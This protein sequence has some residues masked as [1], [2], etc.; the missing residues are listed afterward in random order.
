MRRLHPAARLLT[1]LALLC[2]PAAGAAQ[3]RYG[4]LVLELPAS[5]RALA[6]GDAFPLGAEDADALLY[7][8]AFGGTVRGFSAGLGWWSSSA[9]ALSLTGG[10]EWWGGALGGGLQTLD[11]EA[12]AVGYDDP[13]VAESQLGADAPLRITERAASLGYARRIWKLEVSAAAKLLETRAGGSSARGAAFD[14]AIGRALG[15][16]RLVLAGRHVGPALELDDVELTLPARASLT[17]ATTRAAPLGP[18]D[19]GAAATIA[20]RED[21]TV[22]PGAGV[23]IGYWPVVGRTFLVRAGVRRAEGAALPFT[24]GAGFAGDRIGL[25]W[26][27]APYDDAPVSGVHRINVR[28]R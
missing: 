7:A 8:P 6:L 20:V 21:G 15:P 11:Y 27:Y 10:G 9:M 16:V 5:A 12:A 19:V 17:A 26:A 18:L 22:L 1:G 24:F 4:M 25:D 3:E 28:L 23:E 14:V 13:D 2:A